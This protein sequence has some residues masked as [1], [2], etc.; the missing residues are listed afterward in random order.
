MNFVEEDETNFKK[1]NVKSEK[2]DDFVL[3]N[4]INKIDF[5]KIDVEGF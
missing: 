2:L 5:I 3:K 1:I 4:D